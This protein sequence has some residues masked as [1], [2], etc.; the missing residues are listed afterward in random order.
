MLQRLSV[1][2]SQML[3]DSL[4]LGYI[5]DNDDSDSQNSAS[6]NINEKLNGHRKDSEIRVTR[7]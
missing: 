7:L 1:A 4:E 6:L 5:D 3:P 2:P